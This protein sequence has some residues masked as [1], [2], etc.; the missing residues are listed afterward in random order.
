[1]ARKT[2]TRWQRIRAALVQRFRRLNHMSAAMLVGGVGFYASY[3]H[4]YH[5]SLHYGQPADI[6]AL[7]PVTIDALMIVAGRYISHAKSPLGKGYAVAGFVLSSAASLAA[8][9]LAAPADPF[10]RVVAGWPAICLIMA[11]LIVHYGERKPRRK[12]TAATTK[13]TVGRLAGRTET[14]MFTDRPVTL[15]DI[16]TPWNAPTSPAPLVDGERSTGTRRNG[17]TVG[18]AYVR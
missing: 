12:A 16:E 15:A 18:N 11:A 10:S 14:G 2:L 6:A 17:V 3:Q 13:A 9:I 5:V 1:M 8:N 4:I 7:M